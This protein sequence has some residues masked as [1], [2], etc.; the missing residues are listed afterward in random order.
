MFVKLIAGSEARFHAAYP[1]RLSADLLLLAA[2]RRAAEAKGQPDQFTIGPE[3]AVRRAEFE[4][5]QRDMPQHLQHF[6]ATICTQ[7]GGTRVFVQATSNLLVT[8]AERGLKENTRGVFAS[9]SVIV[10]GG[11][12]KGTILPADWE[13]MVKEF[14]GVN[15]LFLNYGMSE[16]SGL[17]TRCDFGHYHAPPWNIPFI[18]DVDT[19]KPLPRSGSA[20]GRF[21]FFDLLPD[22]RWGGFIT[23]D[24]VTMEWDSACP[25]GRTTAYL[26]G[27]IQRVSAI[28]DTAGEEKI[29][30]ASTPAAYE[31]ALDFLK[32]GIA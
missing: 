30:C 28:R 3:I 27:P 18:L 20:T 26:A 8:L 13:A 15:Q 16:M 24:H 9:D 21:A 11:G 5:Q 12:G 14:L 31:E 1:G 4:A 2:R 22:S 23:G 29:N 10:T 32:D 19:N 25:C 7:F 17:Y 6:F